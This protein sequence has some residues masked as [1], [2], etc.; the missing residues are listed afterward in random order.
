M[1]QNLLSTFIGD[2]SCSNSHSFDNISH[3][4]QNISGVSFL[5]Q[6]INKMT[7]GDA[8][9]HLLEASKEEQVEDEKVKGGCAASAM[10]WCS[11]KIL[12]HDQADSQPWASED[13]ISACWQ[14]PVGHWVKE[15]ST[16]VVKDVEKAEA[17][18]TFCLG[19]QWKD[20][21]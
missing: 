8:L 7:V 12:R 18:S 13:R 20:L 6:V 17:L 3:P 2:L 9:M 11:S 5:T 21:P 16:T 15:P 1:L 10:R 4:I 14:D 19:L